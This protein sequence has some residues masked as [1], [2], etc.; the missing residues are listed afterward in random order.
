MEFSPNG[1]QQLKVLFANKNDSHTLAA[2]GFLLYLCSTPTIFS[3]KC[4][5]KMPYESQNI[6]TGLPGIVI[7]L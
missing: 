3:T 7:R 6:P 1:V 4:K 2:F 5:I